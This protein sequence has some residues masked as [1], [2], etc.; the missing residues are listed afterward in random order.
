[1]EVGAVLMSIYEFEIRWRG[2]KK[3]DYAALT[4]ADRKIFMVLKDMEVKF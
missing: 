2:M 4:E 1:M 3:R